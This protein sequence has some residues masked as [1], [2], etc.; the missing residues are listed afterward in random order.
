[1]PYNSVGPFERT[2]VTKDILIKLRMDIILG[3]LAPETHLVETQLSAD[4]GV[5]RGS[6]RTALQMLEQEGLVKSLTNGRTVVVGF[7]I[8]N[9][10]DMFD[11]RL[12]ME[13]KALELILKNPLVSYRP[14]LD[15]IDQIREKN[16]EKTI[17]DL[18]QTIS[19]MDIHFH[20]S[21]MIMAEHQSMLRAWNTMS[22]V[23]YT[24]LIIANTTYNSFFD[25]Y[26]KHK[27]LSDLIIQRDPLCLHEIQDHILLAKENIVA[28]LRQRMEHN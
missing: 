4:F 5:S 3:T 15:V 2:Q 9:L 18:T 11:F 12:M 7:L 20:R 22:Y 1:M 28:R 16:N 26:K 8:K 10:E 6:V 14:L 13:H 27:E 19:I 24:V 21:I 23:L 25:Y 17:E